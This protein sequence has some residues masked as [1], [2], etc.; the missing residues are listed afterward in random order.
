MRRLMILRHAKSDWP[1]GADD[2]ARPLAPRGLRAAPVMGRYMIAQGLVPDFAIVSTAR[3]TQETWALVR[4]EF[5]AAPPHRDEHRI[6]EASVDS[7]FAVVAGAPDVRTLLMVG[8]NPGSE[9]L[10]SDLTG[11]GDEADLIRMR[12]FP[13]CALAVIDFDT[14]HWA[15]VTHGT[16]RL[17]RY[18][19]PGS[20]GQGPD[21]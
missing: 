4:A 12:R 20:I 9:E 18:V 17:N 6:Y 11:S 7:L 14:E 8:H 19:T 5:G 1:A 3:R 16:G 2:H 21:E 13:T 15:H 10:A